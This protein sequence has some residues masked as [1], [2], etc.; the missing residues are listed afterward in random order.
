[1]TAKKATIGT[2]LLYVEPQDYSRLWAAVAEAWPQAELKDES[3]YIHDRRFGV[4]F[5]DDEGPD[6]EAWWLWLIGEG[7]MWCSLRF[8]LASMQ[9]AKSPSLGAAIAAWNKRAS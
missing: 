9:P 1:M 7:A 6:E 4:R 3:D 2:D 8:T 5:K